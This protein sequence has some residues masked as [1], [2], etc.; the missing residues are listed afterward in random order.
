M[1]I[2][3]TVRRDGETGR[4]GRG[5]QVGEGAATQATQQI[6]AF[7]ALDECSGGSDI[8]APVSWQGGVDA[9]AAEAPTAPSDNTARAPISMRMEGR[10]FTPRG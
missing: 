9:G 1:S 4:P 6:I 10:N 3:P 2:R 5:G 8:G 7:I